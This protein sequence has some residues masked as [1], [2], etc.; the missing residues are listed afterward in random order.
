MDRRKFGRVAMS[1]AFENDAKIFQH[2]NEFMWKPHGIWANE[3][4]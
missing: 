4:L 1:Q 3:R 2:S